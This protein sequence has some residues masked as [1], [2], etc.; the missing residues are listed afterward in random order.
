MAIIVVGGMPGCGKTTVALNLARDL[1][2]EELVQTDLLKTVL[3]ASGRTDAVVDTSHN[4]WRYFG[5]KTKTSL[6][7]GYLLHTNGYRQLLQ[8]VVQISTDMGKHLVMEGV[9]ASPA[10][11][12]VLS[13]IKAGFY[14]T[15][16]PEERHFRLLDKQSK[17]FK[18]NL[19]WIDRKSVV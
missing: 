18:P 8:G 10:N 14:L 16:S 15:C 17:R 7:R 6:K 11:F 9:Q 1:G 5:K 2:L 12:K 3:K 4:S 19:E 13:G